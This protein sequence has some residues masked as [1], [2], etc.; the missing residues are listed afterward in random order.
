MVEICEK[1]I[2]YLYQDDGRTKTFMEPV[3]LV[4]L[5]TLLLPI[6]SPT[7]NPKS[8]QWLLPAVERLLMLQFLPA[9]I[10]FR[11]VSGIRN[12]ADNIRPGDH[13][14]V[15]AEKGWY[16]CAPSLQLSVDINGRHR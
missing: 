10:L 3:V 15:D 6:F 8:R 2:L 11:F 1:L 13:I 9:P 4:V 14:L 16:T 7:I 5:R 12:I